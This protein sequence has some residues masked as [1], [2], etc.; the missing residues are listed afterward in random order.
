VSLR[1]SRAACRHFVRDLVRDESGVVGPLIAVMGV[2]LVGAA[3][4]ALDVGLYY[5][6][7]RKLR[8]A[9]E[10]AA[11]AAAMNPAQATSRAQNYLSRNGYD[12]SVIKKV[13]VGYYCA[14]S[15]NHA[16]GARFVTA[17]D[18]SN[19]PGSSATNAVRLTTGKTSRKFLTGV[20]GSAGPIPDMAITASAARIDEA[21]IAVTSDLLSLTAG[22]ITGTLVGAVNG[23]LGTL[24]GI[25]G[26]NLSGT[27][28]YALMNNNVD[29]G[30]FF[31]SLAKRTSQT[32]T[33]YQLTQGTYGIQDIAYAAADAAYSTSTATALRNFGGAVGNGYK[34]PLA[35]LFGLGVWKNMPVGGSDAAPGPH[36]RA[37]INAYQLIAFAAQAGPG[38]ID[39]SHVVSLVVPNSVVAIRGVG[40]GTMDRPRFAFG[41]VGEAKVGTSL[42]RLQLDVKLTNL[43]IADIVNATAT[44]PLVIDVAA[45]Q[46]EVSAIDCNSKSEQSTQTKVTIHANS[47]LVNIYLG[48]LKNSKAMTK[49]VPAISAADFDVAEL[50][51]LKLL[52]INV[53]S[54]KGKAFVQPVVGAESYPAFGPNEAGLISTSTSIGRGVN[55]GN[56]LALGSTITGLN[57][58]LLGNGLQACTLSLLCFNSNTTVIQDVSSVLNVV[59]GVLGNTADPLLDNVLA[60]LGIQLGSAT[61][62]TT[63][64]RCGAPVLIS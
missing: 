9:T 13:E 50:F 12:A 46:A 63:G 41:P 32:G 26:L 22:G 16:A 64:V 40:T 34:V 51:S 4:L 8:S 35:G 17:A 20:L 18:L 27:D 30:R 5:T 54:V 49:P 53:V 45:G 19:C 56:K 48:T 52:F 11:L 59:G 1:R 61:V 6:E 57:S 7:N 10:A 58:S 38:A 28:I 44:V 33:Y 62:W 55:V 42:L 43:N 39:L 21:G 3:G 23:L 25:P 15:V 31:D 37:G 14:D 36:L 2:A 29:A 60:A 24:L 47:G